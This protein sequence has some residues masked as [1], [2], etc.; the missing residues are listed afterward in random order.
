MTPVHRPSSNTARTPTE[1]P[2][3]GEKLPINRP[4]GRYATYFN[5]A[6]YR[7]Y[8]SPEDLASQYSSEYACE[9]YCEYSY[10]H[11]NTL[12]TTLVASGMS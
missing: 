10:T 5:Y 8:A 7:P 12:V 6:A 1:M 4:S 9:Y 3:F 11:V 2:L